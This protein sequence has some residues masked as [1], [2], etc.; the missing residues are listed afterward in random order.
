MVIEADRLATKKALEQRTR[1]SVAAVLRLIDALPPYT[2]TF[3]I[4]RQFAKSSTSI[5][6]NY[7]EANHGESYDDFLYKMGI[8]LK[9]AS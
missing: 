9:E 2:S 7:R 3:V 4:G 8:A 5:G 6:A 1:T